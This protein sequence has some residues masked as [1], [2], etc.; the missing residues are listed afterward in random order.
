MQL[1]IHSSIQQFNEAEWNI[2]AGDH[3]YVQFGMLKALEDSG[4][5]TSER[6]TILRYFSLRNKQGKL[7]ACAPAMIKIG[8][9]REFGPE[10]VWLQQGTN[11]GKFAWPK[12]QIG[13]PFFPM[14]GPKLLIHP[15]QDA[16]KI[17][18]LLV[19]AITR[20]V[21]G[22]TPY[23]VFNIMHLERNNAER[24]FPPAQPVLQDNTN[25]IAVMSHEYRS[26]WRNQEYAN[27]SA[28]ENS[29]PSRKRYAY[30][31]ERRRARHADLTFQVLN[32]H[33]VQEDFWKDFYRGHSMVCAQHGNAAWLPEQFYLEMG[34]HLAPQIVVFAAFREQQYVAAVLA[35]RDNNYLYTQ[36]W[37]CVEEQRHL[38]FE[39][40][41]HMPIDYAIEH[42]LHSIDSGLSAAHKVSRGFLEEPIANVHWF[43]DT[44]LQAIAQSHLDLKLD[45]AMNEISN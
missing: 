19:Q 7:L 31:K 29:L 14:A 1:S 6:G 35:F 39:L 16:T 41:C 20:Y 37:S 15:D 26:I 45:N 34:T 36:T 33:E 2:C 3:P 4:S 38:C 30:R 28:Y 43:K 5:C 42:R 25:P 9:K 11:Q 13:I 27:Y 8:N 22:R 44:A 32:G 23:T 10:I 40:L 18:K 12:F 21:F 17:E 24:I